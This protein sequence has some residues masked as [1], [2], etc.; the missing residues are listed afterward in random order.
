MSHLDDMARWQRDPVSFVREMFDVEPDEWQV[1]VLRELC[2]LERVAQLRVAMKASKGP[3][4]S[5]VLAWAMWWFMMTR[6]HP[7]IVATAI[8][9]DNLKDNLWAE[10]SKWQARSELLKGLFTWSAESVTANE[11]PATWFMS[12]RA[13]PKGGSASEQA[14]TLA[15]IHA[16]HVMFVLDEAGGIPSSVAAAADGGLANATPGTGRTG[17]MMIAGNPTHLEGPL[18]DACTV[19]A[20]RWRVH[21]VNGD[22]QNPKRSPRVDIAWAQGLIDRYGR[23]SPI[24]LVNVLGKF[25]PTSPDKLLG[26]EQVTT[27]EN[28]VLTLR[29]YAESPKILGVDVARFGDDSSVLTLRQGDAVFLPRELRNQSTVQLAGQVAQ[30]AEKNEVDATC[31]DVGGIG[32]G[33]YDNLVALGV[34]NLHPIDFGGKALDENQYLNRRAE[35][36]WVMAEWVK[37]RG[38]LP[39]VP[40]LR[41]DLVAPKYFFTRDNRIQLESKDDMKKRGLPSPDHGDSL[42]LTH[43]LP[44]VTKQARVTKAVTEWNPFAMTR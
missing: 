30:V 25:P 19:D 35:I 41:A 22:P 2:D 1:D 31:I 32:G 27:A 37:A 8:T 9:K 42:A 17:L 39:K 33:V 13:W 5:T 44:Y 16:D 26:P 20:S 4:K 15:G 36:W 21:E 3:G 38:V 6:R 11:A 14:D 28:R 29:D 40:Q 34:P 12:A 43:S 23:N 10:L 18:Y 24:V 7:K